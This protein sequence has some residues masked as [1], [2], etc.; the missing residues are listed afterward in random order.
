[1]SK[2]LSGY[3]AGWQAGM[4]AVSLVETPQRCTNGEPAPNER[5]IRSDLQLYASIRRN[6]AARQASSEPVCPP[7]CLPASLPFLSLRRCLVDQTIGRSVGQSLAQGP[8]ARIG[9]SEQ[10]QAKVYSPRAHI[11]TLSGKKSSFQAGLKNFGV[12]IVRRKKFLILS[13][14]TL[15]ENSFGS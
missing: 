2:Q 12:Q 14:I 11:Y 5:T 4:H 10:K 1:M 7:A 3:Q 15:S 8:L 13:C 9:G 6:R